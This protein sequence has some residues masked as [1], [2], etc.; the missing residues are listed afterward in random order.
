MEKSLGFSFFQNKMEVRYVFP[1]DRPVSHIFF[2]FLHILISEHVMSMQNMHEPTQ[3]AQTVMPSS[4]FL[5]PSAR[6][7]KIPLLYLSFLPGE[8]QGWGSLGGL[9]YG[10]AQSD[11]TEVTQQEQQHLSFY[12]VQQ[13]LKII[14]IKKILKMPHLRVPPQ[15]ERSTPSSC[16]IFR[17]VIHTGP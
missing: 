7:A 14:H 13:T 17:K 12:L 11:T 4:L 1:I 8:S 5:T 9:F 10:V 3:R 15:R 6:T 16:R 2:F